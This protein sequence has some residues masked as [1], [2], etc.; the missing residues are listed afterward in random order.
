MLQNHGLAHSPQ[1]RKQFRK[2]GTAPVINHHDAST[3]A[4]NSC[5]KSTNLGSGL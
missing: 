3:R 1:S 2:L 4:V 5:T